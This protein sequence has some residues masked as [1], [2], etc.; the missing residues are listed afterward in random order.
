MRDHGF[1]QDTFATG[2]Q[3]IFAGLSK[4]VSVAATAAAHNTTMASS[5]AVV[6]AALNA[7][8]SS[9]DCAAFNAPGVARGTNINAN[10]VNNF[11][12][13][14]TGYWRSNARMELKTQSTAVFGNVTI[15]LREDLSL[16][17][18][19]RYSCLLYTSDAADE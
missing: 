5:Y 12:L 4:A 16:F 2:P 8:V 18:G 9:A 3:S 10:D 15:P 17:L 1:R 6:L 11:V 13:S 7:C 19:G 14:Q